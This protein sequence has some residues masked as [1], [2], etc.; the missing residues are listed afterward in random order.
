MKLEKFLVMRSMITIPSLLMFLAFWPSL[1]SAATFEITDDGEPWCV[2]RLD[3]ERDLQ[4][5]SLEGT[6]KFED[7]VFV[8]I[9]DD[10][11][12]YDSDASTLEL[13]IDGRTRAFA[14]RTSCMANLGRLPE[15]R[16]RI[17]QLQRLKPD[18]TIAFVR[19]F[20]AFSSPDLCEALIQ[21]LRAA[22]LPEQ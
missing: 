16:A 20:Q 1:S 19:K 21:G 11:G 15:A 9:A 8:Q 5:I 4:L 3:F 18:V 10:L 7:A 6:G 17:A 13:S 22:G 14:G 12:I 2:L